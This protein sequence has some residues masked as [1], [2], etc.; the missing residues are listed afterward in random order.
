MMLNEVEVQWNL[1]TLDAL[2]PPP[3]C[4]KPWA[5]IFLSPLTLATVFTELCKPD[6]LDV[7]ICC[8]QDILPFLCLD[9]KDVVCGADLRSGPDTD[10]AGEI[11][12]VPFLLLAAIV[13]A[14]AQF[15]AGRIRL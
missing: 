4:P 14:V 2:T 3:S 8:F 13:F 11:D 6:I 15:D 7:D 5:S 12:D 9:G 1:A 10:D